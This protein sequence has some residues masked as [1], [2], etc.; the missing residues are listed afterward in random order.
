MS[1]VSIL[2]L[3][4]S[5]TIAAVAESKAEAKM[6]WAKDWPAAQDSAR[7]EKKLILIDFSTV[8]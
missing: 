8:W 6:P 4:A 7:K 2:A 5:P 3:A 1:I